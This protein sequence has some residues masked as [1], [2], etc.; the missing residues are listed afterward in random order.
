MSTRRQAHGLTLLETIVAVV[1]F[2]MFTSVVYATYSAA[3][4]AYTRAEEVTE[5][6]QTG[7]V[8]L[9]QMGAELA[10]AYQTPTESTS[11]LTGEDTNGSS[12]ALQTDT[13]TFLTTAHAAYGS[14]PAGDLCQ[15]TYNMGNGSLDETP[16][17][18]VTEDFHPGQEMEDETLEPRL[19]SPLVVGF[20]VLYLPVDDDWMTEW[21]DQTTL[22]LAVRIELTLQP[23]RAGAKPII[24][25]STTNLAMA[26][27]PAGGGTNAQP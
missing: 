24:L 6:Y 20:N 15:V 5:V 9:A 18:D 13:L 16:G 7:R 12:D 21:V 14:A 8:L 22:P 19:L 25:T 23:P 26:T 1:I 3:Y 10:S 17:L 11:T 2:M 27:A 4:T